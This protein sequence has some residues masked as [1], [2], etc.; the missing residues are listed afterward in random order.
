MILVGRAQRRRDRRPIFVDFR[1]RSG[2][3][4]SRFNPGQSGAHESQGDPSKT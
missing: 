2:L 3:V 1:D 4:R